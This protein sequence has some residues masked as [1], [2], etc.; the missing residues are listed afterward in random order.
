MEQ[1]I[2]DNGTEE[3]REANRR[4]E[5]RLVNA[6]GDAEA[7]QQGVAPDGETPQEDSE[8]TGTGATATGAADATQEEADE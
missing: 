4:I 5:F 8:T 6:A 3:G 2:A 7:G 1:P